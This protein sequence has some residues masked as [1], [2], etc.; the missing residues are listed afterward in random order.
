LVLTLNTSPLAPG[1]SPVRLHCRDLGAGPGI[2]FLHSGWGHAIYPFDRQI[3]PLSRDHRIVIPDR[4]GYGQSSAIE[5]LTTDFH[6]RAMEETRSVLDVLGL[7]RPVVWGHSDGAIIALLL[8]LAAP[9]RIAAV[10]VE[11]THFFK[12]KPRSRAFFDGLIANPESL[13]R[14]TASTLAR[15]HGSDWPRVIERHS[16]AWRQI[17]EE[18]ESDSEDFY[19]GR[20]GE[21]VVPVLMIHGAR[22]PRTEPG[23]IDALREALEGRPQRPGPSEL[24]GARVEAPCRRTQVVVLSDG[25]H[26]PHSEPTTADDVTRLAREFI[27]A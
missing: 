22:D 14:A 27:R 21:I 19:G 23:E 26:S 25:G 5:S 9:H 3:G 10:I 15:D 16:R 12:K 8:A 6:Q 7:E 4:S 1:V 13:G 2:V 11:A 18:A 24:G 17:A 20:L